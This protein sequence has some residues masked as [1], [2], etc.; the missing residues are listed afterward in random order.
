[1]CEGYEVVGKLGAGLVLALFKFFED[2]EGEHL[3]AAGRPIVAETHIEG[4]VG[5]DG[6]LEAV[7]GAGQ[8]QGVAKDVAAVPSIADEVDA[9]DHAALFVISDQ[10]ST[11][12]HAFLKSVFSPSTP[13]KNG[14]AGGDSF[15]RS[16][17]H[18]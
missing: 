12:A 1:V 16:T 7:A 18:L 8:V 9:A 5:C 14:V 3:G 10:C 17:A 13:L 11:V 4:K 15:A 6:E 2:L